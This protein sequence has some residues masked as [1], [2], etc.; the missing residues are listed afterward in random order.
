[1]LGLDAELGAQDLAIRRERPMVDLR[2]RL[3]HIEIAR[4]GI[5]TDP[6][7]RLLRPYLPEVVLELEPELGPFDG[8]SLA[9]GPH[10]HDLPVALRVAEPDPVARVAH[11]VLRGRRVYLSCHDSPGGWASACS[12]RALS[13]YG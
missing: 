13:V 11:T 12:G 5:R 8:L 2:A 1:M 6:L 4:V 10:G 9:L 3:G 7:R